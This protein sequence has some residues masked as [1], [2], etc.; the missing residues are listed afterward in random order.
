MEETPNEATRATN[1]L[2]EAPG[3][4]SSESYS[5]HSQYEL[6]LLLLFMFTVVSIVFTWKTTH[7][8]IQMEPAPLPDNSIT[9]FEACAE[10]Y[11][12]MESYP[13]QCRTPDGQLFV[14]DIG[15]SMELVD[16][17]RL[18]TPLPGD[19]ITT[20]LVITGEARGPW[21]FEATFPIILTNWDG[22][23]VA[24]GYAEADGA[25]MTEEFV[26]FSATLSF[27]A[28]TEVSSQGTLILKKANASGLPEHDN[29]LEIPVTFASGARTDESNPDPVVTTGIQGQVLV[30][31]Q[32]PVVREGEVCPDQPYQTTLYV[33]RAN[34]A[35][36]PIIVPT[37][38]EGNFRVNLDPGEYTVE[39]ESGSPFPTCSS[40]TVIVEP[41]GMQTIDLRCDSGIR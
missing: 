8:P 32:C 31:P 2:T 35:E 17:I 3:P 37:D 22:L 10:R 33:Y 20:P 1:E 36:T 30:G 5:R 26:P 4:N 25:W 40:Q 14:R 7:A 6:L 12:V 9:S 13:E 15:N 28:D 16:Q 11:P 24:E 38:A 39:A 21:F 34:G 23:I 18:A 27:K 41:E 19:A 29:A